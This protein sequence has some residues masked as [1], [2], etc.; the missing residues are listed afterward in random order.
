MPEEVGLSMETVQISPEAI[1]VSPYLVLPASTEHKL[2]QCFSVQNQYVNE[3]D[4]AEVCIDDAVKFYL[5]Q[6]AR[7]V[8]NEW[9]REIQRTQKRRQEFDR[10]DAIAFLRKTVAGIALEKR[11]ILAEGI[12][13]E[14]KG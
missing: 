7:S 5:K 4:F 11:A 12:I 8:V 14:Y 1:Q 10:K 2:H 9:E 13:S 6:V 3:T